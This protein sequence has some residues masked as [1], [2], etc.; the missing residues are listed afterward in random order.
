MEA[1]AANRTLLAVPP[2]WIESTDTSTD[3]VVYI[4]TSTGARVCS[5]LVV[6]IEMYA[7]ILDILR[8]IFYRPGF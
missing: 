5:R 3:E 8:F 1:Q 6:Y 2:G 7:P 4:N